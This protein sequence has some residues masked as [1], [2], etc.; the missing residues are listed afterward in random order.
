M[1]ADQPK[2]PLTV[3]D[4]EAKVGPTVLAEEIVKVSKAA[5]ELLAT[6]LNR[7]ALLVLL[8]DSTGVPMRTIE[9]VLEG[10]SEL[11]STYVKRGR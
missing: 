7:R 11:E 5:S 6:R 8:H 10:A 3:L 2:K 9:K 1:P 4:P